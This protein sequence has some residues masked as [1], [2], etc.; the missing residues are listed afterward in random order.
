MCSRATRLCR[1]CRLCS[2]LS[3]S[4][5]V[6]VRFNDCLSSASDKSNTGSVVLKIKRVISRLEWLWSHLRCGAFALI[7]ATTLKTRLCLAICATIPTVLEQ[8]ANNLSNRVFFCIYCEHK[9][10]EIII[11]MSV[12]RLCKHWRTVTQNEWLI[13]WSIVNNHCDHSDPQCRSRNGSSPA[14]HRPYNGTRQ[15]DTP[16]HPSVEC[17]R[18][19]I[20]FC[21]VTKEN[22]SLNKKFDKSSEQTFNT[23]KCEKRLSI[24]NSIVLHYKALQSLTSA[25]SQ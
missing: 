12:S 2:S 15:R 8:L 19:I 25:S 16:P 21:L 23:K 18:L 13:A 22:T 1:L 9:S 20:E 5:P 7:N 4:F 17:L 14:L 24:E 3:K 11:F 6:F 10:L